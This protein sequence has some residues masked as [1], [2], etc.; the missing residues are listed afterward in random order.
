MLRIA[1]A[2]AA[3]LPGFAAMAEPL[4]AVE[5]AGVLHVGTPGDYRPYAFRGD[6]GSFAGADIEMVREFAAGLGVRAEIEQTSWK[7]MSEDFTGGRFDMVV[8]GVS[9]TPERARE[10]D[11]SI[12]LSED[13]KRPVVRCADK[14]LYTSLAA[15]DR[16]DVRVVVN[17]G[18]TNEAFA[19]A[20]FALAPLTVAADNLSIPERL[21]GGQEDVFVTDGVEVDL[22]ARRFAGRLC[23]AA[24]DQPF[25]HLTKAWWL[26]KDPAF[27]RAADLFLAAA[28]KDGRW[29][30]ALDRNMH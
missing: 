7:S 20:R 24:V 19:R 4:D 26:A 9:V 2:L 23:A 30:A 28:K 18:G 25:T 12:A 1:A 16:P 15:I 22:L 3:L 27:K 6:D 21:L 8:G 29:Q 13:G 14:G 17:L 11:F 5:A 10:G